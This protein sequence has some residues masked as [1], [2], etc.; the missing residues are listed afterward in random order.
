[1]RVG[2]SICVANNTISIKDHP[3]ACGDKR[4][5]KWHLAVQIGSSPCVWGQAERQGGNKMTIR[6]IPMR[7]GTSSEVTRFL[8]SA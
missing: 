5:L 8:K 7:V 6:I 3:H 4:Q 2:T 1:M